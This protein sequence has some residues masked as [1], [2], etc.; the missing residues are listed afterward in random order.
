MIILKPGKAV[1]ELMQEQEARKEALVA[2]IMRFI[3]GI[4]EET[5]TAAQQAA[6]KEAL[7]ALA[8]SDPGLAIPSPDNV[9]YDWLQL[10][11]KMRGANLNKM[12][13]VTK[14]AP[15]RRNLTVRD[16]SFPYA[17]SPHGD[18]LLGITV[19]EVTCTNG[20]VITGM[21]LCALLDKDNYDVQIGKQIAYARAMYQLYQLA[22][23]EV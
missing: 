13:A 11:S 22:G 17:C 12:S 18:R 1:D 15:S 2:F 20:M 16:V 5:E 14:R 3:A 19:C 21:A 23:V 8:I 9:S 4:N 7:K 6:Q 10:V